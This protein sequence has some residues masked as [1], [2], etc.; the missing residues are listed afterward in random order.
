[1]LGS[2]EHGNV[3][4]GTTKDREFLEQL[5]DSASQE[6]PCSTESLFFYIFS[7]LYKAGLFINLKHG[8]CD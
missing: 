8:I 7:Q 1:V 2:C 5:S 3:F 4:S 6:E